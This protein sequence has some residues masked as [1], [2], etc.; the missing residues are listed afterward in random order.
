MACRYFC[1]IALLAFMFVGVAQAA[2]TSKGPFLW[3]ADTTFAAFADKA[4]IDSYLDNLK[5]HGI[6]GIWVQVEMYTQGTV[7]YK[8]TTLT[9]LPTAQKFKTGQW[10]N[11]DYLSYVIAQAKK[12]NMSVIIKFHGSN[13]VLWDKNPNWRMKDSKA[14]DVL[15]GGKLK[16]FCVN[17]PYW[18]K[19]FFPMIREIGA[20]YAVDGFYFDTCQVVFPNSDTCFCSNCQDRFQ[21][22]TG[23]R[24]PMK[25]VD[26]ENWNDP[27]VKLYATK[28]VE[29]L[30]EFYQ[31]YRKVVDEAKPGA[32]ALL[33]VSGGYNSYK[34]GLS[35]SAAAESVT[36]LTP[37]PVNT[38]RM[39]AATENLKRK[40]AGQPPLDER[41]LA[42]QEIS[43]NMNRY[44]YNEFMVKTMLADGGG[45]P[46]IP[47][48]RY[49]FTDE[50][51]GLMGP[52]DLEIA[53]IE[54]GIGGGAKGFCFFGYLGTAIE[55]GTVS[56][57]AWADSKFISYLKGLTSGEHGRW[58]ADMK[59]DAR[60][61]I[62][63]DR[64]ASFWNG[65]YW[66]RFRSVGGVYSLLQCWKKNPVELIS[67]GDP[68]EPG[69]P[70]RR[71]NLDELKRYRALIVPGLDHV[72][73]EDLE[74]LRAYVEAGNGLLLMG[75]IGSEKKLDGTSIADDAYQIFGISTEGGP[76]PS[77]FVIKKEKHPVFMAVEGTG[78]FGSF[79]ISPDK[80]DAAS[81]K[82]RYDDTWSVMAE[83]VTDSGRR[84][85][86]LEKRIGRGRIGYI[87]SSEAKGFTGQMNQLFVNFATYISGTSQLI[88]PVGMSPASSLNVFKSE[89]GLT[90]YL[91][92]LTPDGESNFEIRLYADKGYFPVSAEM[93]QSDGTITPVKMDVASPSG[94]SVIKID[95]IKPTWAIIRIKT[96]KRS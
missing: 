76:E 74:T 20:N 93:M 44:G 9:G 5:A 10:A 8:K 14:N 34:D 58:I 90:R 62:I 24:L 71:L 75:S 78:S 68:T 89:D 47:I 36:M 79:R 25:P 70:S 46:V 45:K 61:C 30:N 13:D 31:K 43:W 37:E 16:N 95:K 52:T 33:N 3:E 28:R 54:S 27:V 85:C 94:N 57:T 77:G 2:D 22:E 6:N 41:E 83:E 65:D 12:R 67:V 96:E 18:D 38:P 56:K 73:R 35:T 81:Y 72:T 29:W 87:N 63:Y 88:M 15:W 17:S 7:N 92:I 21:K 69:A 11:D 64:G 42:K 53:Q 80:N 84:A 49:W 66:K 60:T 40:K 39:Y 48:S 32:I 19:V 23:K 26:K 4:K 59:P 86:V 51:A 82:P 1:V 91:H 55:K 50:A